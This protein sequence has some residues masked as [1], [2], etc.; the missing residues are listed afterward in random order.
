MK[1][2]GLAELSFT[3]TSLVVRVGFLSLD[4][5]H[6]C[7]GS[8]ILYRDDRVACSL[9]TTVVTNHSPRSSADNMESSIH[10]VP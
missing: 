3:I 9:Q 6:G 10:N 5:P 7:Y 2:H 1:S 4:L 8:L